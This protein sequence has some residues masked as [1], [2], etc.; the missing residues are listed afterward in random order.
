MR[1]RIKGG[2]KFPNESVNIRKRAIRSFIIID[3]DGKVD[4][5]PTQQSVSLVV[6]K[7]GL[8]TA[9]VEL[10]PK[11]LKNPRYVLY[12]LINV[13][14]KGEI[15][16]PTNFGSIKSSIWPY[17]GDTFNFFTKEPD[18]IIVFSEKRKMVFPP[19][20]RYRLCPDSRGP[21]LIIL[22]GHPYRSLL[23]GVK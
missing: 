17:V 12:A 3:P 5:L 9:V 4:S 18:T 7:N 21:F 6:K 16:L 13:G 14:G 19:K 15:Q 23:F 20:E 2:H 1:L 10:G 11:K 22:K 8:Y